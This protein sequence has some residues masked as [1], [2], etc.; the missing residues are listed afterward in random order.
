MAIRAQSRP[1]AVQRGEHRALDADRCSRPSAAIHE[2]RR[3]AMQ[4]SPDLTLDGRSIF[5]DGFK[6]AAHRHQLVQQ[7]SQR[8]RRLVLGRIKVG[9]HLVQRLNLGKA[10][11]TYQ[12]RN[13]VIA[14]ERD[15]VGRHV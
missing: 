15:I 10:R 3:Y 8:L 6:E 12:P 9:E 1:A 5:V 2:W 13:V 7:F 11:F 14:A 4:H